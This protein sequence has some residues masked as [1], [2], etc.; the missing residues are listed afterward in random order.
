MNRVNV[1]Q[2][3]RNAYAKRTANGL[4]GSLL[5]NRDVHL[6][7]TRSNPA[8]TISR[9][10]IDV[11]TFGDFSK[12]YLTQLLAAPERH[13]RDARGRFVKRPLDNA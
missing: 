8:F 6:Q 13:P 7:L 1:T 5:F 11:T 9:D 10:V 12:T 2:A 3:A 4:L